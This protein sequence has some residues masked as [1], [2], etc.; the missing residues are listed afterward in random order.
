MNDAF[1]PRQYCSCEAGRS[2]PPTVPVR[3][4]VPDTVVGCGM[5]P[6]TAGTV[7]TGSAD[8]T[9]RPLSVKKHYD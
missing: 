1:G 8:N 7:A 3:Y 6:G 4:L 2:G 5:E 9:A